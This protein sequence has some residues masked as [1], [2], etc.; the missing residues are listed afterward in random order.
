VAGAIGVAA[1]LLLRSAKL[2][3]PHCGLIQ[4]V[5]R[6]RVAVHAC[7]RCRGPVDEP[8]AATVER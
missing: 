3:C 6:K 8:A 7:A 2:T 1:A 4:R 5:E